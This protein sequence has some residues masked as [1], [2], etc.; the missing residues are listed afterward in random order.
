M[1]EEKKLYVKF[2]SENDPVYEYLKLIL[3]MFPGEEQLVMYFEDTKK[4][5]GTRCVIHPALV[6]ELRQLLGEEN[7]VVK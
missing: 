7:V 4:R 5:R 1:P 2:S 6:Q 3:V